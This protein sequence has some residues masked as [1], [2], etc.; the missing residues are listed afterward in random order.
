MLNAYI[1]RQYVDNLFD[2]SSHV[3]DHGGSPGKILDGWF[4][5]MGSNADHKRFY[6]KAKEFSNT[7][8]IHKY[9]NNNEPLKN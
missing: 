9:F 1:L 5:F 7:R 6:E 8:Q 3:G 4:Q 2:L